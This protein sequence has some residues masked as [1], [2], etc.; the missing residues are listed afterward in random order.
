VVALG[1]GSRDF[2]LEVE[3]FPEDQRRQGCTSELP[4]RVA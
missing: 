4:R 2:V 3:A 1:E